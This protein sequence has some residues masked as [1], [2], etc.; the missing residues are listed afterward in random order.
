MT[1]RN[2]DSQD[3]ARAL[4]MPASKLGVNGVILLGKSTQKNKLHCNFPHSCFVN[5]HAVKIKLFSV[6]AIMV[7]MLSCGSNLRAVTTPTVQTLGGDAAIQ[8]QF[9]PVVFSDTAEAGML[10]HAYAIL[11]TGDHD[12]K[13]HRVKAMH[14]VEAATDLLGMNIRG[15]NTDRQP[16]ALSDA[17]L[18]GAEGLLK[19]V[20]G[21]AEV[22]SQ[23]RV[24]KHIDEAIKQIN[25]ALS[26]R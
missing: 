24:T 1:F 8:S 21:S 6:C 11:S 13:G 15:D 7:A 9:Q 20:L 16:Q 10:R 14:A 12:Y 22:K 2:R 19:S 25:L 4:K 23:K 18:R 17:T 26:I 3:F 5:I